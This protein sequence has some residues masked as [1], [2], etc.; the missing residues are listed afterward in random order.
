MHIIITL[1]IIIITITITTILS[2]PLCRY[3]DARP[4]GLHNPMI[5]A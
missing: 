5:V 4:G 3:A 2:V 1:I